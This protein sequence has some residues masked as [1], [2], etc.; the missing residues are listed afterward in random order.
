MLL[1][2][3]RVY[4]ILTSFKTYKFFAYFWQ[5]FIFV[6]LELYFL[7]QDNSNTYAKD[8]PFLQT[9]LDA[10]WVLHNFVIP[11]FILK[12]APAVVLGCLEKALS[13]VSCFKFNSSHHY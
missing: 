1:Y 11:H 5:Y 9:R 2:F 12:Q 8:K 13:W 10:Y 7:N 4:G 3:V 6:C